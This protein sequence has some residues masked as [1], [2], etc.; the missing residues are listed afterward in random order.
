MAGKRHQPSSSYL[1]LKLKRPLHQRHLLLKR[2]TNAYIITS[3]Y[4]QC[5]GGNK[6]VVCNEG[7]DPIY[8]GLI[9]LSWLLVYRNIRLSNKYLFSIKVY[10]LKFY[11]K[12]KSL[13]FG[14]IITECSWA[15]ITESYC[16]FVGGIQKMVA[17]LIL[18][19]KIALFY[20]RDNLKI[21]VRSIMA[22]FTK[23]NNFWS[24]K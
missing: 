21:Y 16:S 11:R 10:S 9:K 19:Q 20:T 2:R 23:G 13:T 8:K 18:I 22:I 3:F 1:C 24:N 6:W 15:H 12:K 14:M 17:P 7:W 5:K 4:Q